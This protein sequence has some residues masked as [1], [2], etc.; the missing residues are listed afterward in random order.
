MVHKHLTEGWIRSGHQA[1]CIS[2]SLVQLSKN[3]D[4]RFQGHQ[5]LQNQSLQ[6]YTL[7]ID[8]FLKLPRWFWHIARFGRTEISKLYSLQNKILRFSEKFLPRIWAWLFGKCKIS[9]ISLHLLTRLFHW[10]N[11]IHS[12]EGKTMIFLPFPQDTPFQALA[13][14]TDLYHSWHRLMPFS[15]GETHDFMC[16]NSYNAI[17]PTKHTTFYFPNQGLLHCVVLLLQS[18]VPLLCARG[19]PHS[20]SVPQP[21]R[22]KW[23]PLIPCRLV[24]SHGTRTK[25]GWKLG[26]SPNSDYKPSERM[27]FRDGSWTSSQFSG[28]QFRSVGP[29]I[30]IAHSSGAKSPFILEIT[31][32]KK[33]VTQ[34]H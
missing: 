22:L 4:H 18:T 6:G 27:H 11:S 10:T 21:P 19:K 34:G 13:A 9:T 31:A 23:G 7:N 17:M 12:S 8:V 33:V 15:V 5:D 3:T 24:L 20:H 16:V 30:T 26:T 32:F 28:A 14:S 2:G 25:E 1:G 29:Y